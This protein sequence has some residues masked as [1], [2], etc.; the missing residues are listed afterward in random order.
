MGVGASVV[1]VLLVLVGLPLLLW[2]AAG[3]FRRDGSVAVRREAHPRTAATEAHGLTSGEADRVARAV[4]WGRALDDPRLRAA[5]VDWAQRVEARE[6]RRR[7]RW[8][9]LEGWLVVA[10]VVAGAGVVAYAVFAVLQD[11]WGDVGWFSAARW[12]LFA[13]AGW[14]RR[15]GLARAIALNSDSP[16]TSA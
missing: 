8:P 1:A 13:G 15:Q 10:V 9:Q 11:R 14:R 5:A 3:L 7:E 12:L 16:P 6:Q 2:W 4:T